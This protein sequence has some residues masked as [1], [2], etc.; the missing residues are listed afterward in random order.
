M[1]LQQFDTLIMALIIAFAL[2]L[3]TAL[4]PWLISAA[5]SR[6]RAVREE[7]VEVVGCLRCDYESSKK[8]EKGDYVG[9]VVGTCPKDGAFLVVKAIYVERR[10]QGRAGY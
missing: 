2:L 6:S 3:L 7:L 8:H 9:K 4:L 10:A 1:L 5:S